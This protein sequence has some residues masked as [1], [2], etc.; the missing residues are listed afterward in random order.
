MQQIDKSLV[1]PQFASGLH[2]QNCDQF[3]KEGT[4]CMGETFHS[5]K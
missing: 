2:L 4:V 1:S 5:S 3:K